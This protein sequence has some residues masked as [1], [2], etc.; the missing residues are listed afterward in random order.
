MTEEKAVRWVL[1]AL[2][3]GIILLG[4]LLIYDTGNIHSL[5]IT[6]HRSTE[7]SRFDSAYVSCLN[8]NN[9]NVVANRD[10]LLVFKHPDNETDRR[11]LLN[12][13]RPLRTSDKPVVPLPAHIPKSWVVGCTFYAAAQVSTQVPPQAPPL[14]TVSTATK[15][16]GT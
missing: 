11:A 14:T 10:I 2:T 16:S 15:A 5:Q 8:S 9:G 7:T 12:D 6:N 4:A 3:I 13:L 1:V